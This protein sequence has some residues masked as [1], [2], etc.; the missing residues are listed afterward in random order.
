MI[1]ITSSHGLTLTY[2]GYG[3][4]TVTWPGY[5]SDNGRAARR[6]V[7]VDSR[8]EYKDAARLAAE[9]F[10]AWMES[11]SPIGAQGLRYRVDSL[12]IAGTSNSNKYTMHLSGD[13]A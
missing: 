7:H 8:S 6:T 5:P 10:V 12:S 2:S 3:K 9:S 4:Y 13:W 1:D 11:T